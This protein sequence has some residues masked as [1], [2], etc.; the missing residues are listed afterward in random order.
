MKK[1]LF[2]EEYN[3][4]VEQAKEKSFYTIWNSI[5]DIE[6][7]T[8][9]DII[10]VLVSWVTWWGKDSGLKFT[11]EILKDRYNIT[12]Q[13]R[14]RITT[15]EKRDGEIEWEDYFF[16]TMNILTIILKIN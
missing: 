1:D 3:S 15:R 2:Y 11:S 16:R 13:K 4:L 8:K 12:T 10:L 6:L 14:P 7:C 9:N 5:L